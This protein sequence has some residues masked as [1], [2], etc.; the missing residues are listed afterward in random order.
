LEANEDVY[1]AGVTKYLR[2]HRL[3]VQGNVSFHNLN[4]V[5]MEQNSAFWSGAF[6]VELGI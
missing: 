1:T 3:K 4:G 5:V 6:Q 2:R